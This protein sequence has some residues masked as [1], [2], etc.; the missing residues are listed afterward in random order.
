MVELKEGARMSDFTTC[1]TVFNE[2]A[3]KNFVNTDFDQK[4]LMQKYAYF[5]NECSVPCGDYGFFWNSRGPYS[6]K[7]QNE[8]FSFDNES[9]N[10][11]ELKQKAYDAFRKI[12]RLFVDM[13]D[14]FSNSSWMELLASIHFLKKYVYSCFDDDFVFSELCRLKPQFDQK[15]YFTQAHESLLGEGFLN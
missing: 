14:G 12:R 9:Y 3:S 11:I 2:L 4:L 7:L 6:Q 1:L 13:P 8:M 15:K 5:M 10:Y